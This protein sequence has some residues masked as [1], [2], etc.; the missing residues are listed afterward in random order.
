MCTVKETVLDPEAL[1]KER[2]P[3]RTV[4]TDGA[5]EGL[6]SRKTVEVSE[7][8]GLLDP[9]SFLTVTVKSTPAD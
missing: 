7:V 2:S 8:T 1:A 9:S 3:Y 5:D 4:V 6:I